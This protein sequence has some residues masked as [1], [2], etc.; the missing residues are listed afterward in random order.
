MRRTVPV[1]VVIPAHDAEPY[2]GEC[3]DSVLAQVAVAPLEV[4]VV[5][6]G[7]G[8]RTAGVAEGYPGVTCWRQ[9]RKGPAAARNA[10]IR[11]ARGDLIAFLDADDLWP[12]DSL[13]QRVAVLAERPD[14]ALV[15]GDC[16]QFDTSGPRPRTLFAEGGFGAPAWGDSGHVPNAYTRLLRENFITTGSV[17]VR[18]KVVVDV[19]G[20]EETLS[21][22]ED[23]D[24]WLRIAWSHPVAWN[25][26]VCLMRRRHGTNYSGSAD[27]MSLAYLE[28]LRR[29]EMLFGGEL[30]GRG[31]SLA[32][33]RAS[34]YLDLASRS[35]R[36]RRYASG[37]RW[38]RRAIATEPAPRNLLRVLRAAT[39]AVLSGIRVRD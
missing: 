28:V 35:L 24:L 31:I 6:D 37:M 17:V 2:L 18:R 39:G 14:A 7:S 9:E 5:D 8:D 4:L 27:A 29:Q 34:E 15:F 21:L 19:G 16:L 25:D 36:E 26:S 23:L 10:A 30:A 13:A 3:L 20:F 38:A 11:R 32:P 33:L 12:P 22:V 1:S